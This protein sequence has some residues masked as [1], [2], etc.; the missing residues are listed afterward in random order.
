MNDADRRRRI[1]QRQ[2]TSLFWRTIHAL[3]SLRFALVLL[4]T[5]AVACAV[6]TFAESKLNTRV[7]QD[8][9]YRAPWFLLWLAV[10]CVNLAS[11]ALSRWPWQKKHLGFVVTHAGIIT[12]LLGA[13]VG[14]K[15]GYEAHLTLAK[16]GPPARRLVMNQTI[17][18]VDSP[19]DGA[20]Y[21]LPLPVETRR[22]TE[23]R[24]RKLPLPD[25]GTR[26]IVDG[27][28]ENVLE[29]PVL[30]VSDAPDAAPGV[31]LEFESTMM[32][33]AIP[34]PLALGDARVAVRDFFGLARIEMLATLDPTP[35]P[36]KKIGIDETLVLFANNPGQPVMHS[37]SGPPS[38]LALVLVPGS[39]PGKF[40]LAHEA[41]APVLLTGEAGQSFAV[42]DLTVRVDGFWP[43]FV[44]QN[45]VPASASAE[46]RNPAALVRV[47]GERSPEARPVLQIA[48]DPAGGVRYRLLRKGEVAGEGVAMPDE[49]IRTG[50]ADWRAR[51]VAVM[52]K[53]VL[54]AEIVPGPD[55]QGKAT[56]ESGVPGIRVRLLGKSGESGLPKWIRSGR[57]EELMLGLEIIPIGFGLRTQPVPFS[58]ELLD[59][60][61]PRDEGTDSPS[62]FVSTLLF[63]DLKTG[64]EK[65]GISR[66][67]HP[68][69]Y[70]GG[71]WRVLTGV[72]YKFSQA[73]WNPDNLDETTLQVLY[74]PGWLFKWIG[75]L[76]IS[77]G[78]ALLFYFKPKRP[79]TP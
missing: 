42:G 14:M 28:S 57:S 59:F 7:A 43:D 46:M 22:P 4:A 24:P 2:Q 8:F 29:Q 26:L 41:A 68:A 6:A 76:M 15:T 66:M 3:G 65:Q 19:R 21:T 78:I 58:I 72:N 16:G 56:D 36:V 37:H 45:G 27:Y 5:I 62:N 1:R 35:P 25:T 48:P 71:F 39:E 17:L 11:A 32:G 31:R 51:V 10:L 67:N 50:W 9:I 75:S 12:L 61:V 13:M 63:K 73:S 38:Q 54:G 60:Q 77:A 49:I 33:Q 74:D 30:L 55:P 64:T 70:P 44:M 34:V 18:Q 47:S 52:P 20:I 79:A 69:S 40:A 53:A 23:A